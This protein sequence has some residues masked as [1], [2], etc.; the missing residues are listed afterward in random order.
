MRTKGDQSTTRAINRRLV[1][2]CLRQYGDV[3]RVALVAMTKLSPASVTSVIADL[4]AENYVEETEAGVSKGGRRPIMLRINYRSHYVIGIKASP[5]YIQAALTDLSTD[6]IQTIKIALPDHTPETVANRAA[7]AI[8]E[9]MPDEVQRKKMLIGV[10]LCISGL[11]DVENGVCLVSHRYGWR[12]VPI[13]AMLT[14]FVD[15]PV[16]IDNDVNAYAIAHHLFGFGRL[17]RSML[18]VVSGA[19]I[20]AGLII[21][22]LIHRGA[23]FAAGEVG[24]AYYETPEATDNNQRLNWESVLSEWSLMAQ[25]DKFLNENNHKAPADLAEAAECGDEYAQNL[26]RTSGRELGLRIA[27]LIDLVDPEIVVFGG[28]AVRFGPIYAAAIHEAVNKYSFESPPKIEFDWDNNLWVRGAS[29]L[30]VQRFFDF[31]SVPGVQR[32]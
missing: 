10:G 9:L 15:V 4:L 5:N 25:W 23:R 19:G 27:T 3:S 1:L 8:C 20:G 32:A 21:N 17:H 14:K 26:L 18:A 12:N 11:V 2:H 29:A 22:G 30:A 7:Q 13:A 31:E 16:W 6:M 24:R 28:E